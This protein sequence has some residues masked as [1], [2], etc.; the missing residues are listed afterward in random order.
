MEF[1]KRFLGNPTENQA[2]GTFIERMAQE[3]ANELAA[4]QLAES[5]RLRRISIEEGKQRARVAYLEREREKETEKRNLRSQA[6][7]NSVVPDLFK[8]LGE[9]INREVH[10]YNNDTLYIVHPK[11]IGKNVRNKIN[12]KP[13]TT[14]GTSVVG[15]TG[16]TIYFAIIASGIED[17]SVQIGKTTLN[18]QDAKDYRAVDRA[19]EKAYQNPELVQHHTKLEPSYSPDNGNVW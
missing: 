5:E 14:F 17:G 1:L 6:L 7:Q 18:P 11:E 12:S 16:V 10:E 4:R 15:E 3:R 19:L 9:T 2:N 8:Q 13:H